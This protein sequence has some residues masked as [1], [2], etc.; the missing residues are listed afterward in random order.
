M[1]CDF[2]AKQPKSFGQGLPESF[3]AAARKRIVDVDIV[4]LRA[5]VQRLMLSLVSLM[6]IPIHCFFFLS[7]F[8]KK[9]NT[10]LDA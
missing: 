5:L 7:P 4:P 1:R 3:D 6:W 2:E 10:N 9:H 8:F